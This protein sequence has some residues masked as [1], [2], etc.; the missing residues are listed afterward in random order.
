MEGSQNWVNATFGIL[1]N[2]AL[3]NVWK[4]FVAQ[5]GGMDEH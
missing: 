5:Q 1:G 3:S 4:E 2:N